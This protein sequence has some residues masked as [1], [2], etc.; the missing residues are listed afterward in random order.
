MSPSPPPSCKGEMQLFGVTGQASFHSG[1][2]PLRPPRE[3]SPSKEAPT[4]TQ[5]KEV[6][7]QETGSHGVASKVPPC[8][9]LCSLSLSSW[10]LQEPYKIH[11]IISGVIFSVES[12]EGVSLSIKISWEQRLSC[13]NK[14]HR[15]VC[16]EASCTL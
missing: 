7:C 16:M 2:F 14:G 12:R 9:A 8:P 3:N 1:Q 5:A 13:G 10:N 4:H 11:D 15:Q 6:H